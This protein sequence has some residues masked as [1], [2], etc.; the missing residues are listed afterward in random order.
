MRIRDGKYRGDIA[1]V[2]NPSLPNGFVTVLI[3]SRNL[4]YTMSRKS[5][6]L[7]RSRLPNTKAVSDILCDGAVVGLTYKGE[8]YY[9][10]L[11]LKNFPRNCLELVASPHADDIHLHL[12]SGW[13]KAFL[14]KTVVAFSAQFLRVGDCARVIQGSLC[15]EL[16]KVVS[17]D[18]TCGSV[19]L[20]LT[21][22]DGVLQDIEL[23]LQDIERVFRVSDPVRVVAGSFLGLEGHILQMK[24]DIFHVCQA[25]SKE[26]V[27]CI[28]FS[29]KKQN[30]LTL[31]E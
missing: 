25:V 5:E 27:K 31:R 23:P 12:E 30:C 7:E 18:H 29:K 14:K 15:G 4:P 21:F 28:Y 9:M 3:A 10:G 24:E 2:F 19:G 20:K 26:E 16:S 6:L 8:S 1:Q 17:T 11:L 13:N 22:E